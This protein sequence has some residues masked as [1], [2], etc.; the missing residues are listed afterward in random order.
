MWYAYIFRRTNKAMD[1]R[2]LGDH[3]ILSVD[4]QFLISGET[5]PSLTKR[6]T[7]RLFR[8]NLITA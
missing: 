8:K 4:L 1:I 2:D 3:V 5:I 6:G 7:F